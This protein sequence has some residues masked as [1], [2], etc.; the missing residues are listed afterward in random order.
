VTLCRSQSLDASSNFVHA[1]LCYRFKWKKNRKLIHFSFS[2]LI[3]L[4]QLKEHSCIIWSSRLIS[5]HLISSELS[6]CAL[7]GRSHGELRRAPWSDS[8][9]S[10]HRWNEQGGHVMMRWDERHEGWIELN[11]ISCSRRSVSLSFR[12]KLKCIICRCIRMLV[13]PYAGV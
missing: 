13:Y 12:S 1:S 10:R 8:D 7:I 11:C 5:S 9:R 6:A 2:I 3:Q 4:V